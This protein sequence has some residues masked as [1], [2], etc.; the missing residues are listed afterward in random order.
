MDGGADMRRQFGLSGETKPPH[1]IVAENG[2]ELTASAIA[3]LNV[4]KREYQKRYMNY[5]NNTAELTGTGRPVDG[6]ISPLAPHAAVI[7][8]QYHTVGYSSFVNVLDY[9]SVA[10]PVTLADQAVDTRHAATFL[11]EHIEWDCE[12]GPSGDETID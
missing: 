11:A 2:T 10:I 3:A 7:P 6:V 9:T 5:W 4:S 12:F 1:V 8:G